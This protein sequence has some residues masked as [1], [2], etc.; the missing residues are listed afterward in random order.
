QN[1]QTYKKGDFSRI[2]ADI[3]GNYKVSQ[4]DFFIDGNLING[5]SIKPFAVN[6]FIS[7]NIDIR[8]HK[9][10]IKAYDIYGNTN[11]EEITIN[12]IN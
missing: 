4:A 2:E 6:L 7:P 10:K 9:I 8:E 1:Q 12:I 11:E 3:Q 5:D